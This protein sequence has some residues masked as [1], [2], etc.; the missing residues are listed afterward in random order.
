MKKYLI[1]YAA[2][3]TH[4]WGVNSPPNA[5]YAIAQ[6]I[7]SETGIHVAGFDEV[8][9]FN[10]DSLPTSFFQTHSEH[11]KHTRGAGYW[12]WKSFIIKTQLE[13]IN[14][15]DLLMYSDS[16]CH[17]VK[18]M[19][20]IFDIMIESKNK[21]LVFN[22]T[23]PICTEKTWTKRDCLVELTM[24]T[25]EIHCSQQIMS[26]FF[27]CIKNEFNKWFIDEWYEYSSNFHLIAD[28]IISPSTNPNYPEF[29]EHRHDQSIFSLLSKKHDVLSM[30]DITQHGMQ[31]YYIEHSRRSN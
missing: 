15:G 4:N 7:N 3:G 22:L 21:N 13:K 20:P 19:K 10:R 29:S 17:F 12:I 18:N 2:K 5:G 30:N 14:D 25:P 6:K 1:N 24:D 16:G 26:T 8:I 9:N 28:E 31:D 27:I 11:F 23:N